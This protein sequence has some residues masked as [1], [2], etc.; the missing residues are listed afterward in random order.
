MDKLR[1]MRQDWGLKAT[2]Q[3]QGIDYTEAFRIVPSLAL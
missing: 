2:N 3:V 1:D